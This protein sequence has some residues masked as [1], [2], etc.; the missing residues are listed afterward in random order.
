[1]F[2]SGS[3]FF[4]ILREE[5]MG[6]V[7]EGH[8][9]INLYPPCSCA[10]ISFMPYFWI[11]GFWIFD[12]LKKELE[13]AFFFFAFYIFTNSSSYNL[14]LNMAKGLKYL[15]Y[16]FFF[17][18]LNFFSSYLLF[19]YQISYHCYGP[20]VITLNN[21]LPDNMLWAGPYVPSGIGCA[22]YMC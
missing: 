5:K 16:L 19:L 2:Q 8:S 15:N 21:R 17:F 10:S 9:P 7:F 20:K 6:I 3:G 13:L 4:G 18:S 14:L 1:L 11:F 12:F 22:V